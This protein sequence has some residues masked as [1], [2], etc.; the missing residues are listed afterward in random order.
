MFLIHITISNHT[1]PITTIPVK[2]SSSAHFGE[3]IGEIV[4]ISIGKRAAKK[5]YFFV[6]F[7]LTFV[8]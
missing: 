4:R 3:I 8:W 1:L 6:I 7:L 2:A 5:N